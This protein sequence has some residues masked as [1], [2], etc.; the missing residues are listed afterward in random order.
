MGN[1][2]KDLDIGKNPPEE[3]IINDKLKAS[4]VLRLM[5]LYNKNIKNVSKEY[6]TID[7]IKE[8]LG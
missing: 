3:I 6:N 8:N 4:N 5:N 2:W 7:K 1:L